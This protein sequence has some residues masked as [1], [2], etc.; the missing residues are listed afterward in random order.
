MVLPTESNAFD[1]IGFPTANVASNVYPTQ[2][3]AI[4]NKPS[5]LPFDAHET[6][7]T[8]PAMMEA[9]P[10]TE[11][12][13]SVITSSPQLFTGTAPDAAPCQTLSILFTVAAAIYLAV[14]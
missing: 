14:L 9:S 5:T 8:A 10:T 7:A 6:A 1:G 12:G 11:L 3:V 4:P 13:A 2:S